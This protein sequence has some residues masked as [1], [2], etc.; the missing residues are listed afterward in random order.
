MTLEFLIRLLIVGLIVGALARLAIPGRN[1]MSLLLTM[2]VGVA[3]AFVGGIVSAAFGVGGWLAFVVAVLCA[4]A[5]V[6]AVSGGPRRGLFGG[7][8]GLI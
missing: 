5:I 2:L 8:R 7:R 3:G 6:W 1:P 4:A